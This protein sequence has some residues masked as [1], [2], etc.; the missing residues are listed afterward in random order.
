[1]GKRGP[2][3]DGL[4]VREKGMR[5]RF[6]WLGK[7]VSEPLDRDPT[8]PN[9]AWAK[10]LAAEIQ[11]KLNN[12]TYVYA[13]YFPNSPRAERAPAGAMTVRDAGE[14][15]IRSR[16]RLAGATLSQYRNDLHLW[17]RELGTEKP[18]GELTATELEAKVGEY[19]WPSPKRCNN[20]LTPLRGITSVAFRDGATSIDLAAGIENSELQDPVPDPFTLAEAATILADIQEHY[21]PQVW[22]YFCLAFYTGMRPEEIVAIK[23]SD[24]DW[25]LGILKVQRAR[26][27]RGQLKAVKGYKARTVELAEHAIAALQR[28]KSHTFMRD[29]GFI[30][31]NPVTHAPYHDCRA[32]RENYWTPALKR[33]GIRYR[34]P[35]HTRHTYATALIMGDCNERWLAKQLGNSPAMIRKHYST[36]LDHVDQGKQR[37]RQEAA[38]GG[39]SVADAHQL[40]HAHRVRW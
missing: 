28:Q 30:F 20:A 29:H 32:P 26:S 9:I 16:G 18:I 40:P 13:D 12:G 23:W 10:R 25:N 24:L 39:E 14:K 37:A 6:Q 22:N 35:Y 19:P 21:S 1:M 5:V 3:G 33:T 31:E 34:T 11:K 38:L 17:Y 2:K 15:W 36:W 8:P 27:F 7:R 4:E